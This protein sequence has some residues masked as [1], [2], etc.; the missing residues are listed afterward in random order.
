M[1]WIVTTVAVIFNLGIVFSLPQ[2][3]VEDVKVNELK[4][5]NKVKRAFNGET[6]SDDNQ[7]V[8][9]F[10]SAI[11]RGASQLFS[12]W[13]QDKNR[14]NNYPDLPSDSGDYS[15]QFDEKPSLS[16]IDKSYQYNVE[17]EKLDEA[18]E[19]A[20]LKSEFYRDSSPPNQYRYYD[21][22]FDERRRKR[23]DAKVRMGNRNKRNI[24]LS[25]EEWLTILQIWE[26]DRRHASQ[27]DNYHPIWSTYDENQNKDHDKDEYDVGDDDENWLE[28]PV[29][30]HIG[31]I[32]DIPKS[33]SN[34]AY[35]DKRGQWDDFSE[36]KRKRYFLS[37]RRNDPTRELRYLNGPARSK[38]E[39][40]TLSQ[41]LASQREPNLPIYHR[42]VL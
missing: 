7:K 42:L 27:K 37:E 36:N 22:Q 21:E 18:L 31:R 30:P 3:L 28:A 25:P 4:Q 39:F 29:Y 13:Q 11:K 38:N 26:N 2:S 15:S 10:S 32:G 41:L 24:D 40:Y 5:S 8:S 34:F 17:R 20:I 16:D 6:A 19:N 1:R 14:N 9:T 23:R 35:E 33:S 12:D